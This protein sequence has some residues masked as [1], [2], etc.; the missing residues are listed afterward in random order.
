M[1]L[2]RERDIWF[3]LLMSNQPPPPSRLVNVVI[4]SRLYAETVAFYHDVLG[5]GVFHS[6]ASCCFLRAGGA[7]LVIQRVT[8]DAEPPFLPTG[9]CLYIDVAVTNIEQIK[10]K[11]PRKHGRLIKEWE[12]DSGR[13]LLA[14][15]PDGNLVEV[16]ESGGRPASSQGSRRDSAAERRRR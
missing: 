16:L 13:F 15:D 11:I 12:D 8:D 2:S 14:E 9:R 3:T 7:N 5:F 6:D 1:R 10:E 4:L